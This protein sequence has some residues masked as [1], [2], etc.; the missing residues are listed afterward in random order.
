MHCYVA[1][2]VHIWLHHT[3]ARH[4]KQ[5]QHMQYVFSSSWNQNSPTLVIPYAMNIV[6]SQW[7]IYIDT[8]SYFT[9]VSSKP[10]PCLNASLLRDEG[11]AACHPHV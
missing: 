6:F 11:A 5:N 2:Y 3:T 7:P 4:T 1:M 9:L 10:T 8:H